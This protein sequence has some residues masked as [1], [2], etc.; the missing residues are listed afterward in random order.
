MLICRYT[1]LALR[2]MFFYVRLKLDQM[3]PCIRLVTRQSVESDLSSGVCRRQ[4]AHN[5]AT[6]WFFARYIQSDLRSDM[7]LRHQHAQTKA[8]WLFIARCCAH[9]PFQGE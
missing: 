3:H 5:N 2:S 8:T 4:H 9:Q 7:H 6:R 1:E